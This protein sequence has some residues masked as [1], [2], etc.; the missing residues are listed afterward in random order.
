MTAMAQIRLMVVQEHSADAAGDATTS[1]TFYLDTDLA[2]PPGTDYEVLANDTAALWATTVPRTEAQNQIRV[3]AYDMADAEPRPVRAESVVAWDAPAN[4]VGPREVALCLSYFAD[5]NL[6]RQRGRMYIGPIRQAEMTDRPQEQLMG[7]LGA[8]AEGISGLGGIN[9]QWVV[10][11][12]TAGDYRNVSDYWV[13]N[14][15]DTQRRRGL[16]ASSR[17]RGTVDG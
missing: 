9:V 3:R 13:D 10:Y 1:N 11:S 15:W 14:A 2:D 16:P 12:P 8:L 6:P 5:R 7:T 17:L 4:S